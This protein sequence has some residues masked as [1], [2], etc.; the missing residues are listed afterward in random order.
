MKIENL[1]LDSIK[2]YLKNP[3]KNQPVEKVASSIKKFGFQQ[4]IVVDKNYTIIVGHTRYLASKYLNL[5]TIP[6]V[7]MDVDAEKAQAYRIADNRV[8]EDANWDFQLLKEEIELLNNESFD[9]ESLGFEL[10]ELENILEIEVDIPEVNEINE[11]FSLE[12]S[13]PKCG[14]EFD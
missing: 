13:C 5:Q 3:R 2:P 8:S 6:I 11:G 7:V 12:N 10:K 14:Y 1:S 9:L 4:P